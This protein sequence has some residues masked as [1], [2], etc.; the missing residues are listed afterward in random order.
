MTESIESSVAAPSLD[1]H[2]QPVPPGRSGWAPL[3][4]SESCLLV[5]E[6]AFLCVAITTML[7]INLV[8]VIGRP[9]ELEVGAWT[10]LM[11]VLLP[12][13][14][15]IGAAVGVQSHRHIG[16]T[17]ARNRAPQTVQLGLVALSAIV[18]L[19]FFVLLVVSGISV[20]HEQYLLGGATAQ[21]R[22]P[23]WVATASVPVGGMLMAFH[24]LLA[25][26]PQLRAVLAQAA[27]KGA[28]S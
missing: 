1:P 16:F 15:M 24:A 12:W 5:V 7:V 22:I 11:L 2:G 19:G 18:T 13:V 25:L 10:D 27:D 26:S 3:D 14:G 20:V 4:G 17:F 23:R 8:Q 6:K 21:L 28:A 9:L